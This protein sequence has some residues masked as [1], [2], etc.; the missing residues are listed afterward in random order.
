MVEM[1]QMAIQ[2]R[3][4]APALLLRTEGKVHVDQFNFNQQGARLSL[5]LSVRQVAHTPLGLHHL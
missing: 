4:L 3:V 1:W 5:R 2:F